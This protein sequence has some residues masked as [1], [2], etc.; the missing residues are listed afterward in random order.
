M[1]SVSHNDQSQQ[2]HQQLTLDL[3]YSDLGSFGGEIKTPHL[4]ELAKTGVRMS[5]CGY[6]SNFDADV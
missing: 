4:D 2:Y 1:V 3:G 5:D 6:D